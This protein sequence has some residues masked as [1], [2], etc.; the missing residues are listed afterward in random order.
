M[1]L[2]AEALAVFLNML[3]ASIITTEPGLVIV[4]ATDGPM[5][6]VAY[7]DAWCTKDPN[8]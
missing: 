8:A 7:E 6:W 1:C 4:N 5:H 3:S 2:S